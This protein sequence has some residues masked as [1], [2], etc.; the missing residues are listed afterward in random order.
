MIKFAQRLSVERLEDRD[1][2][3]TF[4][5][6]WPNAA[7]LTLSF[8]PDGTAVDG[9]PSALFQTF[10]AVA[11]TSNWQLEILRALQTWAVQTPINIGIVTD[12]GQA[13]G[14]AGPIQGDSRF[15]DIRIY[16]RPLAPDVAAL[17]SPYDVTA[18]TRSGDI[19]FNT[20]MNYGIGAGAGIDLFSAT[21][22]EAGNVFGLAD[23]NTD[24]TSALYGY[25]TGVRTGLTAGD[26]SAIRAL[27]GPRTP[28][29]F[30][31]PNGNNTLATA[32]TMALP[33][34]QADVTTNGD[35]DYYRYTLPFYS[36]SNVTVSV[37]TAGVS[38]LAPKVTVF[39]GSGQVVGVAGTTDPLAGGVTFQLTN[40]A[41]GGTYYFK[42]EGNRPDVFGIGGY[43]LKVDSGPLPEV[44][45]SNLDTYYN[46]PA[47]SSSL[48]G[49]GGQLDAHT[50][51]VLGTATDLGQPLYQS[52][53]RF[54]TA[55][56]ANVEDTT[57]VDCYSLVAPSVTGGQPQT[58]VVSVAAINNSALN[59]SVSVFDQGGNAVAADIIGNDLNTFVVQVASA[60]PGARYYLRVAADTGAT[61][62]A[63]TGSYLLGVNFRPTPVPM[64]QLT[65]ATLGGG[66]SAASAASV[67]ALAINQS[68]VIHYVLSAS[69][70]GATA[71]TAVRMTVFNQNRQAVF[72]LTAL[73]GQTVSGDVYL[74][75][76]NYTV[77]FVAATADGSALAP[78]T[79]NLRGKSITDPI[80]PIPI[81]PGDPPPA[82]PVVIGDP[83][84]TTDPTTITLAITNPWY[85]I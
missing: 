6:P 48:S 8:A 67:K 26:V 76:G 35:V 62:A 83:G 75:A 77:D 79:Y 45:I 59:P 18:G 51:D 49:G 13:V 61:G 36:S 56:S 25:Y 37:Q 69:A 42:V 24:P 29:S 41:P 78:L 39:N 58:M 68:G 53:P 17:N 4:G 70:P 47:A 60:T 50:N 64:P 82:P 43:R 32:G 10:N 14:T 46:S 55:I 38:L 80:D 85:P 44:L 21:L 57:D 71:A 23:N 84:A 30:E 66:S 65:S 15:G 19:N 27:Y 63:R 22:D 54:Y 40:A 16:G 33:N 72:V 9:A 1:V 7:H 2:P 81:N 74:A 12:G 28:D 5:T 3:A 34:I 11:P 73:N 31:G 52:D 20:S